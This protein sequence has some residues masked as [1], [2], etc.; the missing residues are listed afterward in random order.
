[1]RFTLARLPRAPVATTEYVT[2]SESVRW[3]KMAEKR[4]TA[5]ART[6]L[7]TALRPE[8]LSF[9]VTRS[10][11]PKPVPA[12]RTGLS[13]TTRTAGCFEAAAAG[14]IAIAPARRTVGRVVDIT[15]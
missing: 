6:T 13:S 4:P 12:T 1:M 8:T 11:P 5:V 9:T 2:H 14:E 15:A 7:E 10:P 3:A